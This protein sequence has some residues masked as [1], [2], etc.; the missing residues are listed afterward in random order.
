MKELNGPII[1]FQDLLN[2]I[3]EIESK[4]EY[5]ATDALIKYFES[6]GYTSFVYGLLH[7]GKVPELIIWNPTNEKHKINELTI[8]FSNSPVLPKDRI[9]I[10]YN[11]IAPL[12]FDDLPTLC[13]PEKDY[14]DWFLPSR[15]QLKNMI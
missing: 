6:K 15:M 13:N 2:V 11:P 5:R 4:M 10:N 12:S 1:E 14:N 9:I 8:H 7:N 3:Q